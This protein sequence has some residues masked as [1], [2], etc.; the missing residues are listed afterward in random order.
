MPKKV[1]L[2]L[3]AGAAALS[4]ALGFGLYTTADDGPARPSGQTAESRPVKDGEVP[5]PPAPAQL[6]PSERV[7]VTTGK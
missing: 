2:G 4:L 6:K 5:A 3:A 7:V 1:A